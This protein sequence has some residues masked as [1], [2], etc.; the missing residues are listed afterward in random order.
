MASCV[1]VEGVCGKLRLRRGR[2]RQ[3]ASASRECATSCVCVEGVRGKCVCVEGVYGKCVCIEGVCVKLRLRRGSA[4]Q[5]AF[6]SKGVCG[7]LRLRRGS[8]PHARL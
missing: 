3:A 8:A 7:K 4:R 2:A 6:A 1:C 5:V